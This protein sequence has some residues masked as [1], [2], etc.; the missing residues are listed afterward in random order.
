MERNVNRNLLSETKLLRREET[1]TP[2]KLALLTQK[3]V[4]S[5]VRLTF[6]KSKYICAGNLFISLNCVVTGKCFVRNFI[7]KQTICQ[8]KMVWVWRFQ[9]AFRSR[10]CVAEWLRALDWRPWLQVLPWP[11]AGFVPRYSQLHNPQQHLWNSQ[12]V[13]LLPVRILNFVLCSTWIICFFIPEKPQKGR[14]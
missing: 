14:G 13:H 5:L 6:G 11:L 2:K 8:F 12:L 7:W 1:R 9:N 10:P 3:L 4:R